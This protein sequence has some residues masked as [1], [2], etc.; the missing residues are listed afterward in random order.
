RTDAPNDPS[1]GPDTRHHELEGF[2][3]NESDLNPHVGS[4][5]RPNS[6]IQKLPDKTEDEPHQDE[7]DTPKFQETSSVIAH[8]R[9]SGGSTEK[10]NVCGSA[11]VVEWRGAGPNRPGTMARAARRPRTADGGPSGPLRNVPPPSERWPRASG[12]PERTGEGA[13]KTQL[14]PRR[15]RPGVTF[16]CGLVVPRNH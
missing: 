16:A 4:G 10:S 8:H 5:D 7:P 9:H 6:E 11:A 3:R 12:G 1:R 2:D 13:E 14:A 15:I